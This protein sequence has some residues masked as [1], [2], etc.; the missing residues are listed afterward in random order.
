MKR[1]PAVVVIAWLVAISSVSA[2]EKMQKEMSPMTAKK[3]TTMMKKGMMK[4][5]MKHMK[6]KGHMKPAMSDTTKAHQKMMM[7][8][9][10]PSK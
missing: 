9:K 1:F 7:K 8:E 5:S 6:M 2:Q 10:S 3:D 4:S